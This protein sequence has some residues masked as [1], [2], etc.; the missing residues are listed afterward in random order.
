[1]YRTRK[2]KARILLCEYT[3]TE[4]NGETTRKCDTEEKSRERIYLC[5]WYTAEKKGHVSGIAFKRDV[6]RTYLLPWHGH[7]RM[8]QA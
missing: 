1:M 5:R 7:A 3:G 6:H 8:A 4:T 2:R